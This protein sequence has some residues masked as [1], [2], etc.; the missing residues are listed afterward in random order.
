MCKHGEANMPIRISLVKRGSQLL[1]SQLLFL[2][3]LELEEKSLQF[4][5]LLRSCSTAATPAS[6]Q[7]KLMSLYLLPT[8]WSFTSSSFFF[9]ATYNYSQSTEQSPDICLRRSELSFF[10]R[11]RR[12]LEIYMRNL[13]VL[14]THV[15]WFIGQ[16]LACKVPN[17]II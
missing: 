14:H 16:L 8:V 12:T 7:W 3:D 6:S 11:R 5:D 2:Q 10:L 9:F 17:D 1:Y 15:L 4:Q 13:G